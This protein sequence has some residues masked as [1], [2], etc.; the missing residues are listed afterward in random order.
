[1]KLFKWYSRVP[2][3]YLN[4]GAFVLAGD[5]NEF[6]GFTLYIL[7]HLINADAADK[8]RY[9][10]HGENNRHQ[11]TKMMPVAPNFGNNCHVYLL[12]IFQFLHPTSCPVL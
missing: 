3:I 5:D 6:F 10:E 8:N 7:V 2:L 11:N 9:G 12:H 4:L 1:M